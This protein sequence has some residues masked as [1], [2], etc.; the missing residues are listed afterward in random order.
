MFVIDNTSGGRIPTGTYV[1]SGAGSTTLVLSAATTGGSQTDSLNFA[2]GGLVVANAEI[3]GANTYQTIGSGFTIQAN[4]TRIAVSSAADVTCATSQVIDPPVSLTV[5]SCITNGSGST[6][7]TDVTVA[8]GGFPG[9]QLGMVVSGT[10]ISGSPTVLAIRGN[11]LT[12]S[13]A[14][15]G[16]GTQTLTFTSASAPPY[17]GKRI[18]LHNV[19]TNIV[20]VV[21]GGSTAIAAGTIRLGPND[22]QDYVYSSTTAVWSPIEPVSTPQQPLIATQSVSLAGT[23]T[24]TSNLA[25]YYEITA[26]GS[27]TLTI[28]APTGTPADG[29]PLILRSITTGGARTYSWNSAYNDPTGLLPTT[30]SNNKWDY[31]GCRYN[32]NNSKWDVLAV[33]QGY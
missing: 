29:Q 20:S 25:S 10:N 6:F 8:S 15:T 24:P 21:G 13:A 9:V 32:S 7:S 16:A 26:T 2:N 30:S 3:V 11:K 27:G 14:A 19:G 33:K 31:I 1:K 22:A 23:A 28:A 5:A 18:T 12:M 17:S 4:A